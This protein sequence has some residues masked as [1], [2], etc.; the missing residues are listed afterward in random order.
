MTREQMINSLALVAEHAAYFDDGRYFD[1]STSNE[2]GTRSLEVGDG[3]DAVQV[4]M[5]RDDM[6]RLHAALTAS[7]LA[8]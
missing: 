3:V 8:E 5:S 1:W 2:F 7:L 6:V 4:P